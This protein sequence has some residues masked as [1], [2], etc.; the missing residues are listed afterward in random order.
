M[1]GCGTPLLIMML[2]VCGIIGLCMG[3]KKGRGGVGL[4]SG[5]L[6][7][8]VGLL[9]PACL[10]ENKE[11]LNSQALESGDSKK[12]PFCAEIIKAEAIVCRYCQRD[13]PQKAQK[14][15]FTAADLTDASPAL[16]AR[17]Q[18]IDNANMFLPRVPGQKHW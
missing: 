8:P 18:L 1:E 3:A 12:C 16:Q 17:Q 5:V 6:L 4:A 9:I 13:Q 2:V 15:E 10:S 14:A 11:V 7:G